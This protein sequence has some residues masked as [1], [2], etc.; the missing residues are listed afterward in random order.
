MSQV[1]NTAKILSDRI[2]LD[3][4]TVK[5]LALSRLLEMSNAALNWN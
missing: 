4:L 5:E 2:Q 1:N 3:F